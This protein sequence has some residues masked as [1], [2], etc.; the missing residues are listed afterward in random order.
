MFT[1]LIEPQEELLHLPDEPHARVSCVAASARR[2]DLRLRG[3]HRPAGARALLQHADRGA[4]RDAR[5]SLR[6][7]RR[8]R[9]RRPA[10]A[11]QP[12]LSH[13]SGRCRDGDLAGEPHVSE[14]VEKTR[15]F[16]DDGG[17]WPRLQAPHHRARHR[18]GAVR[19]TG[20]SGSDGSVL[21]VATVPLPDGNVLLTLSR[22]HRYRR[23][24]SGRCA[25]ATR[26]W[27]PP[28]GSRASSSPTSPTSC[29]RRLNAI[30][31][32]AEI[33]RTSISASSIPRQLDY[34]RGILDSS[35]RLLSLI[36]DILD[37]ATI[38]AGY[39]ALE[40]ARGRHPRADVERAGL[41]PRARAQPGPRR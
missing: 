8:V 31:G 11:A 10:Q 26:R 18:A 13:R 19:A 36:N 16:Y 22:R 40:T 12:G 34:S 37:L 20:S 41:D 30:I 27:R 23:G 35:H 24:S 14:I 3:R 9:Q 1:S 15:G 5:Q 28:A 33:L 39:M 32:F 4:A 25:S 2:P 7:H 17:D 6:G 29:A 38:E 21:Q